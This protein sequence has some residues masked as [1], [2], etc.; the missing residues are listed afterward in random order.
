MFQDLAGYHSLHNTGTHRLNRVARHAQ[1]AWL[2]YW[3]GKRRRN[4]GHYDALTLACLRSAWYRQPTLRHL[5]GYLDVRRDLGYRPSAALLSGLSA[6]LPAA[7]GRQLHQALN[8]L[9]EGGITPT[10]LAALD[11]TVL[12]AMA[13]HSPPVAGALQ[14][15]GI[16]LDETGQ[17]LAHLQARQE[18]WRQEF[19][20]YL[21]AR[22]GSICVVGNAP[23][24]DN[25]GHGPRIDAS[26]CVV[27]FNRYQPAAD[28]SFRAGQTR[29]TG[30]RIDILVCAPGFATGGL[31]QE[32]PAE[33]LILSGCDMR[34]R[35]Y[36]WRGLLP[37]IIAGQK[38]VTIPREPWRRLV[39]SLHA[40]PSAG[41]L[42]LEWLIE[43]LG[44]VDGITAA[45]FQDLHHP[46]A[47]NRPGRPALPW[48][49]P[50]RRHN[51]TGELALLESWRTGGLVQLESS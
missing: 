1:Q 23:I 15:A 8:L 24:L 30:S 34:Y 17:A 48:R 18:T 6:R 44:E 32:C 47:A 50:D 5:L 35:L 40:P 14:A 16:T 27:R 49:R 7:S 39:R 19:A 4:A 20:G 33:W 26:R 45:G 21:A 46:A 41:V 31:S 10:Q 36:D 29:D 25:A 2:D 38:I 13:T 28:K 37:L 3:L 12:Q 42:L 11:S 43:L 22:R 51:W 9:L